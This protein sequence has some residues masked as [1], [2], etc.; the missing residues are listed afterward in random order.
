MRTCPI[1][2]PDF[3]SPARAQQAISVISLALAPGSLAF[4]R[5]AAER[6]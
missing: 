4:R 6:S 2:A 5:R 1:T 3:A